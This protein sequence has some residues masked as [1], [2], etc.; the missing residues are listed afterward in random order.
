MVADIVGDWGFG[1][2]V[3]CSRLN[4][5]K[6]AVDGTSGRKG[7]HHHC[8][9]KKKQ[10]RARRSQVRPVQL[11]RYGGPFCKKRPEHGERVKKRLCQR[12]GLA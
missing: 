7:T 2:F 6:R 12:N 11:A 1:G 10:R 9:S 4:G 3:E 5:K 8:T